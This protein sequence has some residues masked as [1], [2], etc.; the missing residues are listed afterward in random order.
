MRY[1]MVNG[2]SID[3]QSML[4]I[5]SK[6]NLKVLTYYETQNKYKIVF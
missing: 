5:D 6:E 4:H 1:E 3:G 2:T